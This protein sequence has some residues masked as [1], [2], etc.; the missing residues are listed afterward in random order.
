MY[1]KYLLIII[2]LQK[3]LSRDTI[4]LKQEIWTDSTSIPLLPKSNVL[5]AK[6]K[7]LTETNMMIVSFNEMHG[8]LSAEQC[9]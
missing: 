4:P 1:K 9:Y 3:Y 2:I 5:C 6:N 8:I 7:Q